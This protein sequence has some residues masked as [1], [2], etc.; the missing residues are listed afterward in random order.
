[1]FIKISFK[2]AE[3]LKPALGHSHADHTPIS[4]TIKDQFLIHP[5]HC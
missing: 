4:H 2:I 1:M 3:P 5:K